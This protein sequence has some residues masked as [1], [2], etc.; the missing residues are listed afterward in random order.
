MQNF[1]KVDRLDQEK[2][3]VL[4]RL[5]GY[6]EIYKKFTTSKA[7]NQ[8]ERCVQCGD[9]Y[10]SAVGCPLGN[11]IPHW[12]KTV[13]EGEHE[14]AFKISN[15]SS[16]FPE[17]LGRI[18]PQDKLCEGACTLGDDGYGAITIGAIETAIT[19]NGFGM[20]YEILF[21]GITTDKKVAIIGS[22]PA[23][24][25]A[26]TYLL[27]AG[28]EV[29]MYEQD[30]KPG[31]LL[32]YGIPG[33]KLDKSVVAHRYK[34]LEKAGLTLKLGCEV[35]KDI[36]FKEIKKS[37]DAVFIGVGSRE[38]RLAAI[39]G[40]DH[41]RVLL[42]LD[43]LSAVQKKNFGETLSK[44]FDVRGKNVVVIGGGDTAMDCVR[45][46]LREGADNVACIYRRDADSMPGSQKEFVNAKEEGVHFLFN[47]APK[48]FDLESNIVTLLKTELEFSEDTS[49]PKLNVIRGS[50]SNYQADVVILALGFSNQDKTYLEGVKS[51]DWQE[52]VVDS[53]Y[54]TNDAKVYAGGDCIRGADLAVT[55]ARDGRDAAIKMINELL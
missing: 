33:F 53:E 47:R 29:V 32:T 17:I 40:E 7:A 23:G 20:G 36:S 43:F 13:A 11:Y 9:P 22:G 51:G 15:E 24:F 4:E 6:K 16:P 34:I 42:S 5:R 45:T 41:E 31:G 50:E 12:L 37:F 19:H 25:S 48:S 3:P 30:E 21:P 55:A 27:R 14:L 18:C 2:E 35:G 39:E 10:C 54:R 52:V 26:A 8:A 1:I 38:G 28:I 44:R 49:R 46:S